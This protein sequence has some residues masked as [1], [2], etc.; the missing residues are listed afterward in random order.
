MMENRLYKHKC[1]E[2]GKIFYDDKSDE[3]YYADNNGLIFCSD[4]IG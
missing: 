1:D 4:C 3:E 2:C